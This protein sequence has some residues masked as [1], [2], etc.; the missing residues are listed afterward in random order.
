MNNIA[1]VTTLVFGLLAIAPIGALITAMQIREYHDVFIM[2]YWMG[3]F[4]TLSHAL[5]AFGL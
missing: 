2:L 5:V 3:G 4:S 1:Y